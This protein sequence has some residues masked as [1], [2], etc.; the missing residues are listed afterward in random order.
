M[1]VAVGL[2]G[3][4][5]SSVAAYLLQ[6][7]GY[8]V[9]GVYIQCWDVKVDGCAAD[10]DKAYALQSTV[11]LGTK[12]EHLNF[13]KEYKEK[14]INYFYDEYNGGR[15]PNPDVLCNKEIKFGLFFDWAMKNGFDYIATGHYARVT[16]DNKLYMGADKSKD[17]SY[18]LYL[19]DQETLSKTLFPIGALTK[20]EV[21]KLA[22]KAELPTANRPD[23]MGICF[24]GDV[25]IKEF[26]KERLGE[27]QGVVRHVN[28]QVVGSHDGVWFYTIGQRHGFK[29]DKYF[30]VPL[31]V[32]EKDAEKNEI[33]V[34]EKEHA[35]RSEFCISDVHWVGEVPNLPLV[36]D[37]R[38]R[39]LGELYR[40]TLNKNKVVLGKP[41]FGVAPGQSAVF[42]KNEEVLG[43]GVIV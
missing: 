29:L 13:I 4:V 22:K 42:Y 19:L 16:K 9:T 34:G 1:K 33:V 31:F 40:A 25:D 30:G 8:D 3:G 28:G 23:S 11:K 37:V 38:I 14:V 10:E 5:D 32:I 21:R 36:C 7:E 17:Q 41:I 6:K 27:R 20:K 43:G 26:L 24:V 35:H 39:N 18:F 15:T 2:S 12:F